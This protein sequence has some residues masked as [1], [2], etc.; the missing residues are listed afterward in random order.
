VVGGEWFVGHYNCIEFG[1]SGRSFCSYLDFLIVGKIVVVV[2]VDVEGAGGLKVVVVV[3]V[4]A[5]VEGGYYCCYL[6][7]GIHEYLVVAD[8][9]HFEGVAD[10]DAVTVVAVAVGVLVVHPVVDSDTLGTVDYCYFVDSG[11]MT[12]FGT[13]GCNYYFGNCSLAVFVPFQ[14][15]AVVDEAVRTEADLWLVN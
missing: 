1:Y 3:V 4:V 15:G 2:V 11:N 9:V 13:V 5:V 12:H 7:I 6:D 14:V 8:M 10:R